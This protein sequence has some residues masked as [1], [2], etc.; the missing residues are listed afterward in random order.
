MHYPGKR[1]SNVSPLLAS[2]SF[3]IS[4]LVGAIIISG[5]LS[6]PIDAARAVISG[7]GQTRDSSD[8]LVGRRLQRRDDPEIAKALKKYDLVRLGRP[9]LKS[10]M[11]KNGRLLLNTS[12]GD[13]DLELTPYDLRSP[14]YQSQMIGADGIAQR[15][16]VTPVKTFKGSVNGSARAQARMTLT[17]MGLEGI[18]ITES[19]RYFLQPARTFSKTANDDEFVFYNG[20]DTTES[21]GTCGVT[22]ADEVGARERLAKESGT[23]QSE[24]LGSASPNALSPM[25]VVRLATDADAEYV[26]TL[27]GP[28]QANDQILDIMNQVDGIY[29]VEIGLTFQIVFQNAWS[30]AASDPY[31]STDSADVWR[32]FSDYWNAHFA[33]TQ[34]DLA[35]LWTGKH[36]ADHAGRSSLGSV[37]R[38]P[39]QSYAVSQRFPETPANPIT[40]MTVSLTA[41][42]I[43]HNFGAVH[44]GEPGVV[45]PDIGPTCPSS[46]MQGIVDSST[47]CPFSRSQIL[48]YLSTWSSCLTESST[49]PPSYPPCVET[50]LDSTLSANGELKTTDCWS[51]VRGLFFY[52]D[53]YT[54]EGQAGQRLHINMNPVTLGFEP[55]LYL[56]APDGWAI[57]QLTNGGNPARLPFSGSFTLPQ[58]GKYII[59]LTSSARQAF[60]SYTISVTLDGCVLSVSPTSQHFPANGGS[61]TI[62]VTATGS[63]CSSSSYLFTTF[64]FVT[65]WL[66]VQTN[67]ATGSQSLNFTVQANANTTERR[68]F[69]IVGTVF[70][71]GLGIPITQSGTAPDCPLTPIGFGQTINGTLATPDCVSPSSNVFADRYSFSASAGQEVAISASVPNRGAVL[72]LFGP[73]Q[74]IIL[75]DD[76]ALSLGHA[77]IPGGTGMLTLGL[78]GTYVVEVTGSGTGPYSLTL[79]TS[80]P[81]IPPVLLTEENSDVAAAVTSVTALGAPFSLT[82]AYNFSSDGRTRVAIFVTNLELFP[83]EDRS[84]VA[85]IAEDVQGNTFTL[86]VEYVGKMPSLDW[87][88]QVVVAL[89]GNLP[90]GQEF[91]VRLSLHG[92]SSNKARLAI[93]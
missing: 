39:S 28:A 62:N 30:D 38:I 10:Q 46:I 19:D 72:T 34:R 54:F 70:G 88:S 36:L 74:R 60:G 40:A 45:P 14:D 86:P 5:F 9:E 11:Q 75:T 35:H 48:S 4:L 23:L 16:P 50:P 92:L 32:E 21:L 69:L 6:R 18:V 37:C 22:L 47:F 89:P 76:G 29:Q 20:N 51:S 58:T 2:P 44:P 57:G 79:T 13:F 63:G 43:G 78:S 24:S 65:P 49:P 3:C 82:D 7:S 33:G 17:N 83:G 31:V 52:A 67:S 61:G 27:G 64:P 80:T 73:D 12:A 68:A 90:P 85:A 84:A 71:D 56:I 15:L 26:S 59:E 87:L 77:R 25:R 91:S 55:Y 42:E 8:K 41:H 53:H 93:K 1:I 81:A 66:T